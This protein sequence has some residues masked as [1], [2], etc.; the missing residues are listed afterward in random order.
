MTQ[1]VELIRKYPI[2][3]DNDDAN[4]KSDS[5]DSNNFMIMMMQMVNLILKYPIIL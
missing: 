4:V 5:K 1:M 2:S 3:Y